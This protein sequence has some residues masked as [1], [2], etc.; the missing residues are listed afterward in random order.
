MQKLNKE[1]K[2]EEKCDKVENPEKER[3]TYIDE[4]KTCFQR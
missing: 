4:K 3:Q 2:K 1:K